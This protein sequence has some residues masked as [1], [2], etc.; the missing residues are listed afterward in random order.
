VKRAVWMRTA[1]SPKSRV[2]SIRN[3]TFYLFR[4]P[5]QVVTPILQVWEHPEMNT[6]RPTATQPRQLQHIPLRILSIWEDTTWRG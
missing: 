4:Q 6:V 5:P 3:G 2:K 1:D